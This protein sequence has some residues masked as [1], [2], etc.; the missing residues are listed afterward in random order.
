[1]SIQSSSIFVYKKLCFV[2]GK[3]SKLVALQQIRLPLEDTLP[4]RNSHKLNISLRNG[5]CRV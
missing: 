4:V 2:P 5:A 1:L 3:A